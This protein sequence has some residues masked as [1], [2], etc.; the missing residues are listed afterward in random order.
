LLRDPVVGPFFFGKLLSTAGIWVHNITAVIVV[1]HL[2]GSAA[3]VG[4]VSVAQ[5]APQLL[6]TPWS[7]ARADRA[8]RRPQLIAG[9]LITAVG[10]GGLAVGITAFGLSGVPGAFAVIAAALVVG[11]GFALGG[12]AMESSLPSMVGP[13]EVAAVVALNSVPLTLGRAGGPALGALLV[14]IGGPTLAFSV[15]A[16][17]QLVFA[18][19]LAMV[20]R[21][22]GRTAPSDASMRGGLRYVRRDPALAALLVGTA[23]VG[24][25]ADPAIT[26]APSFADSL[27]GGSQLAGTLASSFGVGAASTFL[28]LGWCSR[29]FG[30]ERLAGGGLLLIAMGLVALAFSPHEVPALLALGMAGAGMTLALTSVTT[31]IQHRAPEELRG[32]IMAL[33][34]IAFLGCRPFAAA[35]NGSIADLTSA[36]VAALG[37]AVVVVCGAWFVRP[38]RLRPEAAA[39]SARGSNDSLH[40]RTGS[41]TTAKEGHPPSPTRRVRPWS[42]PSTRP[43]RP[44]SG[45]NRWR[46]R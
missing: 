39:F 3:L 44:S 42:D 13:S 37:T 25:G 12:P 11:I 32:R 40:S 21:E 8:D 10:S 33:W 43:T 20:I 30:V 5:F 34:A 45:L 9:R 15:A 35:L 4:V 46:R 14:T 1:F 6:L 7:G 36:T 24:I 38:S 23:A 2:T 28:V 27:G 29:R 19:I 41:I 16:A 26:L 18:L 31:L 17:T 22:T